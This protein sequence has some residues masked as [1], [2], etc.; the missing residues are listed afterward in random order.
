MAAK[1]GLKVHQ[2]SVESIGLPHK[3]Y[4]LSFMIMTIEHV[5]KPGEVLKAVHQLLKPGGKVLI[6][7]DNTDALDF[8]LA[9]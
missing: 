8:K 1:S 5:E 3:N 6:I 4:D 9:K 7:T 2:G